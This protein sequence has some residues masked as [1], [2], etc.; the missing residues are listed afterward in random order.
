VVFFITK[1][2]EMIIF[3]I[4]VSFI[5]FIL[6]WHIIFTLVLSDIVN[7]FQNNP[8]ISKFKL[9]ID[10]LKKTW[11][12]NIVLGY[13]S[14]ES[15]IK[16]ILYF[17][18]GVGIFTILFYKKTLDAMLLTGVIMIFLSIFYAASVIEIY[19]KQRKERHLSEET[20]PYNIIL[21]TEIVHIVPNIK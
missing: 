14:F 13:M 10:F 21:T 1:R 7:K 15:I 4:I 16:S 12:F 8:F 3:E 9:M 18:S 2:R 11:V 20:E 5:F 6:E 17:V 19:L